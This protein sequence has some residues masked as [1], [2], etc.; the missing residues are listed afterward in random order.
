MAEE[1]KVKAEGKKGLPFVAKVLIIAIVLIL[2]VVM[3]VGS[4]FFI[5]SKV[6]KT[7]G[8][9][10]NTVEMKKNTGKESENFVDDTK[11]GATIEFGEYTIN[12]KENEPRYLVVRIN[13]ELDPDIREKKVANIQATI[14]SKKVIM[15]DRVLSILRS[16]S[17]AD[18]QADIENVALKKEITD[19]VNRI[20]GEKIVKTVR[21]NNWLIQ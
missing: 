4:A 16:K 14:E 10:I 5:A 21:F 12:L 13:F 18:L 3:S 8:G 19:E 7:S 9:A 20:L 1:K 2:I 17:I 15:Q 6:N 11:F